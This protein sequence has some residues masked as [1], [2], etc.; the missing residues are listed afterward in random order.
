MIELREHSQGVE[1][2]T[3][4]PSVQQQPAE[5]CFQIIYLGALPKRAVQMKHTLKSEL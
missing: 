1:G 3:V 5:R 4:P 2:P